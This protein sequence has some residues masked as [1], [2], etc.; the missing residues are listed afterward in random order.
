MIYTIRIYLYYI[1]KN[2]KTKPTQDFQEKKELIKAEKE[3]EEL[4]HKNK[5]DELEY[6]RETNK[7]DSEARYSLHRLKRRDRYREHGI[8]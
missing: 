2:M 3:S 6:F 4:R 1:Q 5:M 8:Q 7:I